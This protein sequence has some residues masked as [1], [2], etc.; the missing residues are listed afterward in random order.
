MSSKPIFSSYA[1]VV[2]QSSALAIPLLYN[3]E[4]E[5][6]LGIDGAVAWFKQVL[7]TKHAPGIYE[8]ALWG[9]TPDGD[10]KISHDTIL[11][12]Y[13][14]APDSPLKRR[15][16]DMTREGWDGSVWNSRRFYDTPG[17]ILTTRLPEFPYLSR[18]DLAFQKLANL[19]EATKDMLAYRRSS[20]ADQVLTNNN[21]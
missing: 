12:P 8:V 14:A 1:G 17:A 7:T 11:Q 9:I 10:I 15:L 3:A 13:N 2:L 16:K 5:Y 20:S 19:D 21:L 6:H 4:A 18:I